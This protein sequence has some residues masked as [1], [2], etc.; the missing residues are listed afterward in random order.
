MATD[1]G[2]KPKVTLY[3]LNG[4]RAQRI[5]WLLEEC[6]DLDYNIEVF[7]RGEDK[8]APAELKQIH[9]LGKSPVIKVE[10]PGAEPVILAES[11]TMMEYLSE[12][13]ASRLIPKRYR[14]GME[15]K[16]G[17]ETEQWQRYRFY[18]HYAEGSLMS[19]LLMAL[20]LSFSG[21]R[22]APVP[23]FIKPITRSIANNVE[24]SFLNKQFET[25]FGFLES[26]LKSSPEGG[27]YLCGKDLTTAD[28]LMS[29]PLIAGKTKVDANL[30]PTLTAYTKLLESNEVYQ[31][32]IKKIEETSGIPFKVTP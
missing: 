3:W 24:S 17:G 8:L 22:N 1:N 25:H 28:I 10:A 19:P 11:G 14:D 26:Q 27:N 13:F 7:K 5:V 31:R 18:M 12:Y 29:F 2:E 6:T 23:F 32:S 20:L 21:I 30:Y 16:I 15:G 9:P 4:S